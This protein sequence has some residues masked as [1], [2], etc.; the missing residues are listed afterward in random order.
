ML[1]RPVLTT[2][3]YCICCDCSP[4]DWSVLA[5]RPRA[6]MEPGT[7]PTVPKRQPRSHVMALKSCQGE[8][9]HTRYT[10]HPL[11]VCRALVD[12]C[13]L[14]KFNGRA[15]SALSSAIWG[16]L[17]PFLLLLQAL[18]ETG[19][20]HAEPPPRACQSER[21]LEL[22]TRLLF[23]RFRGKHKSPRLT[24]FKITQFG[25]RSAFTTWKFGFLA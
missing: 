20:R 25:S 2:H 10:G 8:L 18:P 24:F 14:P 5:R 11:S 4:H 6:C 19:Q 16:T 17:K 15:R 3:A 1:D 9:L 12:G 7:T 22:L 21:G 13:A 23:F